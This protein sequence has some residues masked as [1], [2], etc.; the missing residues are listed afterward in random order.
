M[1][2]PA[3]AGEDTLL[4]QDVQLKRLLN[5]Q[6]SRD[7]DR[8]VHP[9]PWPSANRPTAAYFQQREILLRQ[10]EGA[11]AEPRRWVALVMFLS[12]LVVG[13]GRYCGHTD[14]CAASSPADPAAAVLAKS[15]FLMLRASPS[16]QEAEAAKTVHPGLWWIPTVPERAHVESRHP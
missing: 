8:A 15:L 13:L 10:T 1:H 4:A 12:H 9:R 14:G 2:L 6:V 5:C 16:S 3:G 11:T 7:S